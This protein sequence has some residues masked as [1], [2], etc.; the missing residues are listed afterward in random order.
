MPRQLTNW[1]QSYID[2]ASYSEAPKY[3]HF[4]TGVSTIAACLRRKVWID[5]Y[6]FRWYPSFYIIIVAPPGII[7]K[8]TTSSIGYRLLKEIEEITLG[9]DITTWQG[10][11]TSF[12]E[13]EEEFMYNGELHSMCAISY[14]SS[15]LGNFLNTKDKDLVNLLIKLWDGEDVKKGT[16]HIG[17]DHVRNSWINIIGCT[18]PSWVS[19]NITEN[20]IQGG[21]TSRCLFIYGEEKSKIVAYPGQIDRTES[22]SLRELLVHD[23]KEIAKLTGEFK[24]TD[25]AIEWG[26]SWYK[27]HIENMDVVAR[28]KYGGYAARKQSHVHKV[29]MILSASER[30]DLVITADDMQL[31]LTMV[32][33]IEPDMMKVFSGVG[34]K[35][36]SHYTEKLLAYIQ[37]RG[38]VRYEEAY[39]YVYR[40]FPGYSNY[41]NILTGL[42]KA[43]YIKQSYL[44]GVAWLSATDKRLQ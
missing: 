31:A 34:K 27:N 11:I 4:W 8:S 41:E 25:E 10:L 29:A 43:N 22:D 6:F 24:L 44:N 5:Q 36:S 39:Q 42:I 33:D 26:K 20:M 32:E 9:D 19:D 28:E 40:H 2:Y 12:I 21:L 17:R 37:Q 18:T 35:S 30:D 3:I 14:N 16:K 7:A 13:A 23:L 15:E 38:T 1:L